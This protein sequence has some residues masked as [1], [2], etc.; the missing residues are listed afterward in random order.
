M[1]HPTSLMTSLA[2]TMGIALS[3]SATTCVGPPLF[4]INTFG[5]ASG[6]AVGSSVALRGDVALAGAPLSDYLV[7]DSGAVLLHRRIGGVW[8]ENLLLV[9]PDTTSGDAFG[10]AVAVVDPQLVAVGAPGHD[11][12]AGDTGSVELFAPGPFTWIHAGTIAPATSGA[13]G[14]FGSVLACD[15]TLLAASAPL[16]VDAGSD[17]VGRVELWRREGGAWVFEAALMPS[18]GCATCGFGASIAIAG[19]RVFV[20]APT[21]DSATPAGGAVHVYERLAGLWTKT[22]AIVA[23]GPAS[24]AEFGAALSCRDNLVAIGAPGTNAGIGTVSVFAPPVGPI[25]ATWIA[26]GAIAA[27]SAT[28]RFGQAVALAAGARVIVGAPGSPATMRLWR[29][30]LMDLN[31]VALESSAWTNWPYDY[32]GLGTRVAADGDFIAVGAP[33][34]GSVGGK[35]FLSNLEP[36]DDCDQDGI[37]DECQIDLGLV[38]DVDGDSV[39]DACEDCN[40]NRVADFVDIAAGT[41][42]DCNGNLEP[43]ECELSPTED[44]DGSGVL[45]SCE[46]AAGVVTDCNGNGKPDSCDIAGNPALDCDRSGTLDT[47]DIAAGLYQDCDASGVPDLC[48]LSANPGL[49]CDGDGQFDACQISA[50]LLADC[51][52][53]GV[54]DQCQIDAGVLLDCDRDGVTNRCETTYFL[55]DGTTATSL[56]LSPSAWDFLWLNSFRVTRNNETIAA[57]AIAWGGSGPPAG[58]PGMVALYVDPDD[59][60]D[61]RNATLAAIVD[62]S[63]PAMNTSQFTILPIDPVVVGDVDEVFYVAGF[64]IGPAGYSAAVDDHV[65]LPLKQWYAGWPQGTADLTSLEGALEMSGEYA[66]WA[67][68][69]RAITVEGMTLAADLDCDGVVGPADLG[70][71]LTAWGACPPPGVCPADVTQD[72]VVDGADLASLLATG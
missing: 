22:A 27:P 61:P 6:D 59:D 36:D 39:P 5:I 52:R 23:V 44:C 35:L 48:E 69:L 40:N 8:M 18:D 9:A 38:A 20:G 62:T 14:R 3:T 67:F 16:A 24:G 19:D 46:V 54:P 41:S 47:C 7:V 42:P 33:G 68:M 1:T 60:G 63:Y 70:L 43:D 34:D 31:W 10:A 12:P 65:H 30:H 71:M 28:L 15:G 58:T 11:E 72:G 13:G 37:N 64:M 2:T 53:N 66:K 57:L 26:V 55:D 56:G 21:D 29:C 4:S 51:D 50:G 32:P 25:N 45:D 17:A 49:D